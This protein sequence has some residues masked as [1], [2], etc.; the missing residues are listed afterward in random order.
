MPPG[1][2]RGAGG[3]LEAGP[4]ERGAQHKAPAKLNFDLSFNKTI[5]QTPPL[6]GSESVSNLLLVS[7]FGFE[8]STFPVC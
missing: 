4:Q 2:S 7:L 6:L 5:V 8:A 3:L 1:H